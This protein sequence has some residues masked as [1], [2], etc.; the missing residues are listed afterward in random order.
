MGKSI[1]SYH[2]A[3]EVETFDVSKIMFKPCDIFAPCAN[4]GTINVNN[5]ANIKAKI[6]VE[7]ANG[8]TTYQAD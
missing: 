5:A 3:E 4:D 1:T 8:P 6:I 7:G 2:D